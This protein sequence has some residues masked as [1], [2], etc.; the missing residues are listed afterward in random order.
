MSTL[1]PIQLLLAL[2]IG[3]T[4]LL[5]ANSWVL[6]TTPV[7]PHNNNNISTAH[8]KLLLL[9]HLYLVQNVVLVGVFVVV[10]NGVLAHQL[11]LNSQL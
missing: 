1:K 10:L 9:N 8:K 2:T 4:S 3:Y 11:N 6:A 5:S 7:N